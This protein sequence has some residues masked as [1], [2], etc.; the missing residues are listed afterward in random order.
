MKTSFENILKKLFLTTTGCLVFM[1]ST[2][3]A[4][5]AR[6]PN[7]Q[8]SGSIVTP[9]FNKVENKPGGFISAS[10]GADWSGF[11]S[12]NQKSVSVS[13][14]GESYAAAKFHKASVTNLSAFATANS[15]ASATWRWYGVPGA[16]PGVTA[17]LDVDLSGTVTSYSSVSASPGGSANASAYAYGQGANSAGANNGVIWGYGNAMAYTYGIAG[18]NGNASLTG[19]GSKFSNPSTSM[20][21]GW[22]S[23]WGYYVVKVTAL[24]TAPAGMSAIAANASGGIYASATTSSYSPPGGN[25]NMGGGN[26]SGNVNG[27][28][29]VNLVYP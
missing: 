13:V 15:W 27:Y 8:T 2:A 4:Q 16:S 17:H 5:W 28:S 19:Q 1:S 11:Y 14:N 20:G 9:I 7:S 24:Y 18:Q 29:S 25:L 3:S 23:A 12:F 22:G 21:T 26:A 10:V 6:D